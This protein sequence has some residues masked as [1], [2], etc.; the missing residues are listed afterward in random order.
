MLTNSAISCCFFSE[1]CTE[2]TKL[3][4]NDD[5]YHTSKHF[6]EVSSYICMNCKEPYL[7]LAKVKRSYEEKQEKLNKLMGKNDK[8]VDTEQANTKTNSMTYDKCLD[9]VSHQQIYVSKESEHQTGISSKRL[10][11]AHQFRVEDVLEWVIEATKEEENLFVGFVRKSSLTMSKNEFING[12]VTNNK[13]LLINFLKDSIVAKH[14]VLGETIKTHF[15]LQPQRKMSIESL[16]KEILSLHNNLQLVPICCGIFEEQWVSVCEQYNHKNKYKDGKAMFY[17]DEVHTLHHPK[18]RLTTIN[19]TVRST[20]TNG[21][22]CHFVLPATLT[23]NTQVRCEPCKQLLRQCVRKLPHRSS[24]HPS[25]HSTTKLA[26]MDHQQLTFRCQK[27]A[28]YI[29]QLRK[30]NSRLQMRLNQE[31]RKE[32]LIPVPENVNLTALKLSSLVD[33]ALSKQCLDENSVL[34]ALLCDTVSSL[35]KSEME[36]NSKAGKRSHPK[37]MRFHPVVL[38]WCVE[39]ANRCGKGGYELIR[40][41]LPIPCISTVNAYRQSHKSY[42]TISHENLDVFSQE[43]TRR[44]SKGIGGIHWDEIHVRKGIKVCARTNELIGFED[45]HIPTSISES[46]AFDD[47][48][49]DEQIY[50]AVQPFENDSGSESSSED[51]SA[52]SNDEQKTSLGSPKPMAKIILQFFWSSLE[53]DFTWPVASFP[54]HKIN[55]KTLSH[56]VW[57]TVNALSK[58]KFGNKNGNQVQVL[59]GVCD[60]ATHSSA[61]FNQQGQINWMADNPYNNNKPIF[62]LSDPPHM[63]KKLRNFIISQNRH[64]CHQGFQIS[65]SHLMEVAERGLTKLSYK[66]LFLTSRNKMSVKRAVETCSSDVAE[67]MMF[68]SKFGFQETLMTRMYLRK[69]AKYFRI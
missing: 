51:S 53:G 30:T 52:S 55:A 42:E 57:N 25:L 34:Y 26:S 54:L 40:D 62:W 14:I 5:L 24:I 32:N 38:K 59:Y 9:Q 58:V 6:S 22:K 3:I 46:I 37:G 43:L 65:L 31:K 41:V 17:I 15:L 21:S 2:R 48:L 67:D 47:Y 33:I 11:K 23:R 45:L 69:V 29:R 28:E 50:A 13:K 16:T 36:K 1:Y 20:N 61:F 49:P 10:M 35:I 63:I 4:D 18:N 12:M 68:H 66:H 27:M 8:H 64:L 39:L 60:G 7:E 44:N 56:C 19:K